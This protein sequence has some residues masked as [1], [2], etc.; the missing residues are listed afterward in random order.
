MNG[1][2]WLALLVGALAASAWAQPLTF[3]LA[4]VRAGARGYALSE[5]PRG[6]ERI[7]IEVLGL[8]EGL[9]LPFPLVLVQASGSLIDAGGGVSAG[10]SGSPVY[11]PSDAGEALLG[12]IAYVFAG[13]PGGLAMVTPI[14]A[15]RTG[16]ASAVSPA[17]LE[18]A[19]IVPVATPLL[20][21]GVGGRALSLLEGMVA[22]RGFAI[23]TIPA[24]GGGSVR[25]RAWEPGSAIAVAWA[26]GDIDITAVGT[27]T[28]TFAGN[29]LA[30]GHPVLGVGAVDWPLVDADITAIVPHTS[31]PFKLA[32]TGSSVRGRVLEDATAALRG[33]TGMLADTIPVTLT[34]A[35]GSRPTLR[36]EVVRDERLWPLLVAVATFEAMERERGRTGAGTATVHWDIGLRDGPGL[37]MSERVVD[38]ADA[39]L[40]SARLVAAPLWLLS[41]N[42]F[43]RADVSSLSLLIELDD[44]RRDIEVMEL[45]DQ[46]SVPVPGER[47]GFFMRLQPWRMPGEVR[48]LDI[49]WPSDLTGEIELVVRGA[50]EPRSPD[51]SGAPR[52]LELPLSFDELL[53]FLRDRARGG[54]L[55]VEARANGGEWRR[56]DRLSLQGFVTGQARLSFFIPDPEETPTETPEATTP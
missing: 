13:A 12:A 4:D 35:W 15:M 31:V 32:N 8:Q 45:V 47:S 19:G 52:P 33:R 29:L 14:E 30:F 20:V 38:P 9:G 42:P 11:L 3:P 26:L 39:S 28:E 41:D 25:E 24:L 53:A 51:E 10:M 50:T 43:Q 40:A 18:H 27:L 44:R 21:R 1:R 34:L 23:Q 36:F 16:R 56:L 48:P 49:A 5:G 7:N 6:I 46:G 55:V 37:R 17:A 54:D 2:G 22:E